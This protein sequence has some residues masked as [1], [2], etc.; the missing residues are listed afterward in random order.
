MAAALQLVRTRPQNVILVD[1]DLD[2]L[3]ALYR[4]RERVELLMDDGEAE[5]VLDCAGLDAISHPA[6]GWLV[7]TAARYHGLGGRLVLRHASAELTARL[8]SIANR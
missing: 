2:D 6:L 4:L 1:A 7:S 5:I 8:R 3:D